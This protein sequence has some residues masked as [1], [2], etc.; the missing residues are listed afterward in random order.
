MHSHEVDSKV[1]DEGCDPA[2]P[3]PP[4][5]LLT[6]ANNYEKKSGLE[7]C[8]TPDA[9][10]PRRIVDRSFRGKGPL[11]RQAATSCYLSLAYIS[12]MRYERLWLGG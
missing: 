9:A 1:D 12:K 10:G 11:A 4:R 3:S 5:V 7:T 2:L 6:R 8:Q